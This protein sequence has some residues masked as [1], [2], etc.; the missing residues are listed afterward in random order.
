M[1]GSSNNAERR[2]LLFSVPSAFTDEQRLQPTAGQL[3]VAG[4][5]SQSTADSGTDAAASE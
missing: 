5:P 4:I 3:R 1:G 2:A